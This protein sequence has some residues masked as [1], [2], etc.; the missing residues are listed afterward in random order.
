MKVG[1][2]RPRA[3]LSEIKQEEQ[4]LLLVKRQI[5]QQSGLKF[6]ATAGALD[7]LEHCVNTALE[8]KGSGN[9]KV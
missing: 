3:R 1:F 8:A 5:E 2:S 4:K 7:F 6:R 9:A